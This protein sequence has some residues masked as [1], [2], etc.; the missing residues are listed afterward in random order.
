MTTVMVFRARAVDAWDGRHGRDLGQHFLE[1][2]ALASPSRPTPGSRRP[3]T[4]S[5][6]APAPE[7]SPPR[8]STAG[9]R[10]SAVEVDPALAAGLTRRFAHTNAVAV[11][12]CDL[13]EFP[14]PA[15]PY[16]VFA[17]PPFNRTAA[18]L[19]RLLDD[20]AGGLVRAD[21]VVQWQVARA[22][23]HAGDERRGRPRR[24]V[25]GAVVVLPPSAPACP[26]SCS[27]RRRRS[28]PR[29]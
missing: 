13:G 29:C 7:P 10:V 20:P 4:S 12:E 19:H 11:Y 21:L 28:M 3:I 25:L 9:A 2:S 17:N 6:S 15:T 18:I 8:S 14:L 16:R 1:S 27:A 5:S 22:L 24:R 26:P 23:A